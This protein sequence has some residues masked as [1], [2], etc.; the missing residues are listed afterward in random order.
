MN[1]TREKKKLNNNNNNKKQQLAKY[2]HADQKKRAPK[3]W[4]ENKHD[5]KI[6]ESVDCELRM[7]TRFNVWRNNKNCS[8]K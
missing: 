3:L 1:M 2:K 8:V 4:P 6:F 5:S 7:F